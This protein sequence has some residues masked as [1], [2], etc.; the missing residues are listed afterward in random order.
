MGPDLNDASKEPLSQL[1]TAAALCN[2][3]ASVLK[4]RLLR[5]CPVQQSDRVS[6]AKSSQIGL[7]LGRVGLARVSASRPETLNERRRSSCSLM[8]LTTTTYL[9]SY[10]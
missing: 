2:I 9:G 6:L 3:E 7:D 10:S 4:L 5:G 1:C 8:K